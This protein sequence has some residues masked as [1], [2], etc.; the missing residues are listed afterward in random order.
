MQTEITEMAAK[1]KAASFEPKKGSWECTQ[2]DYHCLCDEEVRE[3]KKLKVSYGPE[4][5]I[6]IKTTI[7][8][9]KVKLF[10][11]LTT[12]NFKITALEF[13]GKKLG[14]ITLP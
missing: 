9:R 10:K 5:F 2:C 6:R 12:R 8:L 13:H 4:G 3:R 7:G 11:S 1:I 14:K